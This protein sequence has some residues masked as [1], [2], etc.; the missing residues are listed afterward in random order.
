MDQGKSA[1]LEA[2]KLGAQEGGE[3]RL[4]RRGKLPGLF[5]QRNRLSADVAILAI[6]QK[7]LEDHHQAA[8]ADFAL[9]S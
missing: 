1:L 2:L 9:K 4:Y 7:L 5:A 3:M 8:R 6:E